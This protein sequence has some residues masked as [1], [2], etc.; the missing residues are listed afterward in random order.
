MSPVQV[1]EHTAARKAAWEA[2]RAAQAVK[3]PALPLGPDKS[4]IVQ[5]VEDNGDAAVEV[6]SGELRPK[7]REGRPEGFASETSK[8]TGRSKRSINEAIHRA[9]KIAP[10][11]RQA[12]VG[13]KLDTGASLDRLAVANNVSANLAMRCTGAS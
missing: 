8:K 1:A 5:P 2:R 3:Q 11:V 7:L 4:G 6:V 13:T 10:D 12:V 9:E